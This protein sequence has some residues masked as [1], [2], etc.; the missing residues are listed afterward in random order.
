VWG[1]EGQISGP[2]IEADSDGYPEAWFTIGS[3][4]TGPRFEKEIFYVEYAR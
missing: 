3:N 2:V 1:Y 4:K